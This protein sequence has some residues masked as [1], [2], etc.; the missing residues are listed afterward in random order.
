M[1]QSNWLV[2]NED[3]EGYMPGIERPSGGRGGL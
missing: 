3:K 1:G 2:A